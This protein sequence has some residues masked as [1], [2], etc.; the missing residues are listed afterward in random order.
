MCSSR[1]WESV[2]RQNGMLKSLSDEAFFIL[3][4]L[5]VETEEVDRRH[6][7][8]AI[9]VQLQETQCEINSISILSI[10]EELSFHITLVVDF[11]HSG[12]NGHLLNRGG[13]TSS[14]CS[15]IRAII[16]DI[17]PSRSIP[18]GPRRT[19]PSRASPIFSNCKAI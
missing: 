3:S 10:I 13:I 1:F 4:S 8:Q 17:S 9:R 18:S 2:S 15:S 19:Y 11:H 16:S 5:L 7:S 14:P 6:Q 12:I